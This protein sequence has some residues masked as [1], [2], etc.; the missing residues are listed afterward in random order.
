MLSSFDTVIPWLLLTRFGQSE[1]LLPAATV[2]LVWL[3]V[4][5]D[6]RRVAARWAMA[7]LVAIGVTAASKISFIGWGIG[8]AALNFTGVSGHTMMA[9]AVY[10]VLLPMLG[11]P[12][13]SR[14]RRLLL[15]LGCVLAVLVGIS[16][17]EV[18]AHSWSEV[19][20]GWVVGG[21]VAVFAFSRQ[22]TLGFPNGVVTAGVLAAWCTLALGNGTHSHSHTLITRLALQWSGHT[23][24]HTRNLLLTQSRTLPATPSMR[25]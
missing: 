11:D 8:S 7:L 22:A 3:F 4:Q 12:K 5:T 2:A 6:S 25:Q 19:V 21:S 14:S 16:R 17:L 20:A 23:E 1:I 13:R 9:S 18:Q 10:P 15:L 24:P